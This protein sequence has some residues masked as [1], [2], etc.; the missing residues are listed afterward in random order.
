MTGTRFYVLRSLTRLIKLWLRKLRCKDTY[1]TTRTPERDQGMA[2]VRVMAASPFHSLS[3][4]YDKVLRRLVQ[5]LEELVCPAHRTR[6]I[7]RLH[8]QLHREDHSPLSLS[9]DLMIPHTR[10]MTVA[11]RSMGLKVALHLAVVPHLIPTLR[12]PVPGSMTTMVGRSLYPLGTCNRHHT[13]ASTPIGITHT[14]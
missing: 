11:S 10:G 7:Q 3:I 6:A 1:S 13:T 12:P 14:A 8:L 4:I 5:R 2:V 9:T